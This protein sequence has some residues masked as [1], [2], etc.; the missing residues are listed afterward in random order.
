MY[1]LQLAV[2]IVIEWVLLNRGS[3]LVYLLLLILCGSLGFW[4]GFRWPY[5][6][7][8]LPVGCGLFLL[9]G[10]TIPG[11]TGASL[12]DLDYWVDWANLAAIAGGFAVAI[13]VPVWLMQGWWRST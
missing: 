2:N 10:L 3:V 8:L 7:V 6:R 4:R 12:G 13:T 5:W 1:E 11:F 9:A